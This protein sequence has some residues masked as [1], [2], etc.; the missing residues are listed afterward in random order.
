MFFS[1]FFLFSSFSS[2]SFF[3]VPASSFFASFISFFFFFC[4]FLFFFFRFFFHSFLFFSRLINRS[5]H[6]LCCNN[7]FLVFHDIYLDMMG[8]VFYSTLPY[9]FVKVFSQLDFF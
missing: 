8:W 5:S 9:F 1:S 4:F 7:S 3:S 6:K 2:V